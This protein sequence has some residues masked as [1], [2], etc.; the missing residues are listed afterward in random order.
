MIDHPIP[1]LSRR[2]RAAAEWCLSLLR[3]LPRGHEDKGTHDA[4]L[5]LAAWPMPG[6]GFL[7][8]VSVAW[9]QAFVGK[10]RVSA[11]LLR[12]RLAL[13]LRALLRASAGDFGDRA[14]WFECPD[15]PREERIGP[16]RGK[17]CSRP[18]REW[19]LRHPR[20]MRPLWNLPVDEGGG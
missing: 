20:P 7:A 14:P 9:R 15:H 13:Y 5:I 8:H 6:D 3:A 19:V 12:A 18:I 2:D 4:C 10:Q 1:G 11:R 17:C 16:D